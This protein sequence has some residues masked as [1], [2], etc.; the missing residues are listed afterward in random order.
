MLGLGFGAPLHL[1]GFVEIAFVIRVCSA[2][3]SIACAGHQSVLF[4]WQGSLILSCFPWYLSYSYAVW[5]TIRW[6]Q[7]PWKFCDVSW[8]AH[9]NFNSRYLKWSKGG[10]STLHKQ[11]RAFSRQCVSSTASL[12]RKASWTSIHICGSPLALDIQLHVLFSAR[13]FCT[14][15][16]CPF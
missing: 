13:I 1:T 7:P 14:K 8:L 11:A 3:V 12:D 4:R 5:L 15:P 10:F 9:H 16:S 6:L 2:F